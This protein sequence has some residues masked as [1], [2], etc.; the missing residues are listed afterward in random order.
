MIVFDVRVAVASIPRMIAM[1]G[2][3]TTVLPPEETRPAAE[4]A[5]GGITR[6]SAVLIARVRP[7]MPTRYD[8]RP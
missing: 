5:P 4:A 8:P 1:G 7:R 3:A 6:T 2:W